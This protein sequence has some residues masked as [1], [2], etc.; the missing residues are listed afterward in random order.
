MVEYVNAYIETAITT[1][2]EHV[3]A[4]IQLRAQLAVAQSAIVEKD[5]LI[6]ALQQ[7]LMNVQVDAGQMEAI[8][9]TNRTLEET[10]VALTNKVSHL[11][12]ALRQVS[13]MKKMVLDR[14]RTI[15]HLTTE[16]DEMK[17]KIFAKIAKKEKLEKIKKPVTNKVIKPKKNSI[18]T[19]EIN[20]VTVQEDF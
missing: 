5:Q 13:D 18:V 11:D 12:T 7:Q 6:V 14:E 9:S 3:T 4:M 20:E 8:S 2:H 17:H 10:N 16:V 1:L 15:E 19:A